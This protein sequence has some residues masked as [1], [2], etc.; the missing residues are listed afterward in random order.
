MKK[1]TTIIS[2]VSV[3]LVVLLIGSFLFYNA[4]KIDVLGQ[5]IW[6]NAEEITFSGEE[7]SSIAELSENLKK[8]KS[9][10]RVN[11]GSFHMFEEEMDALSREFPKITFEYVPY[12]SVAG[13]SI[14][15]DAEEINL[16]GASDYDFA[17]LKNELAA[18]R[19]L[20]KVSFGNDAIKEDA[21]IQLQ[22]DLPLVEFS[23]VISY[24]LE[25]KDFRDDVT[26]I[27][28]S[29]N[30]V[31]DDLAKALKPF[32]KLELVDLSGTGIK[33][34][35]LIELQK[36]FPEVHFR[37][38]ITLGDTVFS[39]DATKIDLNSKK[40]RDFD[41]FFDSI[42]LFYQLTQLE[43]CDSGLSDEQMET[44][45]D[46]YPETK[47]VW[48]IHLGE[49]SLRTDAVAFSVM[50]YTYEYTR[51]TTKDIQ[52]LKYCTDLQAL[53]LG[54]QAITDISVIGEYL[55][56]LRILILADNRVSD[57]SPLANLPHL[58]Y[59]EIFVNQVTDL[60]PLAKCRE[61]VDLNISYNYRLSDITPILDLPL[62][63]RLW[64]EHT[65]VSAENRALLR[66]TY[67]EATIITEGTGSIDQ[68][69]RSHERYFAMIDMFKKKN[70]MSEAFSKYDGK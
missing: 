68:G 34:E 23:A 27:N 57:L 61:L 21:F 38:E 48:R 62:L 50:I 45:R 3:V 53:D 66:T 2:I 42:A 14:P 67:P 40:I 39:T 18:F 26:E 25:G 65:S 35:E 12:K 9:L 41:R 60:T 44:L 47:F 29:G 15:A 69:W 5:K 32:T 59:F 64:L 31:R 8:L 1:R 56:D 20:K 49:W 28:L 46:A 54:H 7:I 37:A 4:R 13:L 33:Y 19:N 24:L 16:E 10:K 58:H 36:A 30:P 11:L 22:N 52:A 43:L 70:Y 17:L 6:A 55:K 51:L 63:E